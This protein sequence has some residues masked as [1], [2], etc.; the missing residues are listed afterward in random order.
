MK[1]YMDDDMVERL[2]IHMLRA[3]GNDVQVPA[4]S[5][6]DGESDAIHMAHAILSDRVL[7]TGNRDDFQDLHDLILTAGGHH[8]GVVT[9][10]KDNDRRRDM[11]PRAIVRAIANLDAS[12]FD[13]HDQLQ[14]LN[15]WR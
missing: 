4:D 8:A 2:L 5:G 15:N 10:C 14:I 1:L 7:V 9:I 11:S 3:A 6:L 13:L 12:G